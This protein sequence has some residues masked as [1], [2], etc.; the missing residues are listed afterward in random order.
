MNKTFASTDR[1]KI[2]GQPFIYK[3][4][5]NRDRWLLFLA[6]ITRI[7]VPLYYNQ[8]VEIWHKHRNELDANRPT[9]STHHTMIMD[10]YSVEYE[11][12]YALNRLLNKGV[13]R[14][15]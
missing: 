12:R 1:F 3:A 7:E 8:L 14:K 13:M 11:V 5:H 15:L 4:G 6:I 9:D 2:T 10:R